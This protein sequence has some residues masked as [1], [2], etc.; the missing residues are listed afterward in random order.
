MPCWFKKFALTPSRMSYHHL[1]VLERSELMLHSVKESAIAASYRFWFVYLGGSFVSPDR[2]LSLFVR[3]VRR[4]SCPNS[5]QFQASNDELLIYLQTCKMMST[6][7]RSLGGRCNL[8]D[9]AGAWMT[10]LRSRASFTRS[11]VSQNHHQLHVY[12][13]KC[14]AQN[15]EGD[16]YKIV[17]VPRAVNSLQ[18][19]SL[20][21]ENC[22]NVQHASPTSDY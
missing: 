5:S 17:A 8:E 10:P 1:P 21:I 11:R 2:V 15:S 14:F 6:F 20:F 4:D 9:L 13:S 16:S 12:K 7:N 19:Q 3:T 22:R 18:L